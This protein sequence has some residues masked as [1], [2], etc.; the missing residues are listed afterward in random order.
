MLS[1]FTAN[2]KLHLL[3]MFEDIT[4]RKLAEAR[5]QR[6]TN[7]YAALS[8]CN[9]AIVRCQS[10]AELFPRVCCDVV[11]YG[12]MKMAWIGLLD[13]ANLKVRPV[14]SCGS[15]LEYLEGIDITADA[16]DP[17]GRGPVG[18][19]I[20]EDC[21]VWSQDFLH[22]PLTEPWHERAAQFGWYAMAALPLRRNGKV[23]GVFNLYVDE[24]HAF[25]EDAR[26]LLEEM[27][28]DISFALDGFDRD[29]KL[30]LAAEVFERGKEG[31]TITD[32]HGSIIRV[33]QAFSVI[34]GYSE[35]EVVGR[36]P[37]V[38]QSG[39][40]DKEFYRLM[41]D[42]ILNTGHWQGEIW[43][44]RKDGHIYPEWL[45]ISRI[46]GNEGG[47]QHYIAVFEDITEHKEA[48]ERIQRMAHFDTLT[49]LP[50]RALLNDRSRYALSMAQ[51][52]HGQ[53]AVLFV[54]L[55]HFKNINDTLGHRVGD[56]LLIEV[57]KRMKA[58]VRDEDTVSRQG[59]DEFIMVLPGTDADGAAHVAEKLLETVARQFNVE[60][61]ELVITPSIGIAMYPGDGEDFDTLSKCADTAMYRAKQDGRNAFRFFTAEMQEHSAR[62]LQL[63][64]ALRHA[65]ERGQLQ[66]HYQPQVALEDGRIIGA[67][68][69]LRW[70]HPE[71]GAV[72]PAEFIPVAEDS[73]LILPIGEWVLRS[74]VRQMKTWLDSGLAPMIIAVNLSAVQFRH[75]NLPELVSR[76]LAEEG[77]PSQYLELELTEGVA[78]DDPLAAIAVMDDL[79]ARGI[80][81]SIDDFGTGYS[82]LSY[83]KRFQV[84]KL[85]ID[86][87]F[88]RD[89]TVD[90]EDKAIV[91]AIISLAN[92][93]GLQTIAEGVET[94][95]QLEF[96]REQGCNEVQGYFYSKPVTAEEF[97]AFVRGRM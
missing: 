36:N 97:E 81:M 26:K 63:E 88:V 24:N 5:I 11:Q 25:D 34:T 22:D 19:A 15:G 51:R 23:V 87:S 60:Q 10:E 49:G 43:N 56:E 48:E 72:S 76:I 32:N 35:A 12:G 92:S 79:H 55:D 93:L 7:L 85:K 37:R 67:E 80:R 52:S 71:L 1:T 95:G 31:I 45:T 21:I 6:L 74:A 68:A 77:L 20:R 83:L 75:A 38:L 47:I 94:E 89:I 46:L 9:Q 18:T 14:A 33:N 61:Y 30:R 13:E 41:W 29:M 2:G 65:L 86:Q 53:L 78:M 69:L 28:T 16:D 4:E 50:N 57:A 62:N 96:L 70:R 42:S 90:T 44:R 58:A 64:N 82:S 40:H 8:E 54:D 73:G 66:L 17:R 3:L 59:G 84:Y 39:R 91:G 27:G